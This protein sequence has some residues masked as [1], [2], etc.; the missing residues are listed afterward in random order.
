MPT[1]D[2]QPL[3][4][5]MRMDR[6]TFH[7]VFC[8]HPEIKKAELIDGVVYVAS[9]VTLIHSDPHASLITW[10]GM[11]AAYNPHTRISD[12]ITVL[13]DGKE[14]QPDMVLSIRPTH[15]GRVGFSSELYMTGSPELIGEIAV[16]S[17]ALDIGPRMETYRS[18]GVGEYI[19]WRVLS[20]R[21]E[22]YVL[23]DGQYVLLPA[24]D[25]GIVRSE[26]FAGLWLDVPAMLSENM[27][28][29]LTTLRA[30][31]AAQASAGQP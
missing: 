31:I 13:M 3:E 27:L 5:G 19:I 25:A 11:W 28:A 24:D 10:C 15:G 29:V 7:R 4:T 6:E 2:V 30:G 23:R 16:S 8:L 18:G 12:N 20:Q 26:A 1:V 21:I 9:P 22:W 14:F 17:E